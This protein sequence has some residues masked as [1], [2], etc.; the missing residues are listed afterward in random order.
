MN[1]ARRGAW[2]CL[3]VLSMVGC[4]VG[5]FP[6]G[7]LD[8]PEVPLSV[9]QVATL[10][11][12]SVVVLETR[13]QTPYSVHVQLFRIDGNLYLD[14]APE[15]RWLE[16]MR[17][18]PAVRVRFPDDPNVYLARAVLEDNPDVLGRFDADLVIVRLDSR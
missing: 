6:G 16:Y 15:R 10:D 13:P 8:G 17:L 11:E 5:P 7:R 2:L 14:P 1:R 4:G 18:E 12:V 3:L 9:L